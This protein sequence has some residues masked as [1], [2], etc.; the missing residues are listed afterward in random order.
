MMKKPSTDTSRNTTKKCNKSKKRGKIARTAK[1]LLK[2]YGGRGASG[3][4]QE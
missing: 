1:A 3:K 2:T 4:E